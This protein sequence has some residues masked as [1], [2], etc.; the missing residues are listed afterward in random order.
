MIKSVEFPEDF[1]AYISNDIAQD[2]TNQKLKITELLTSF[3][4]LKPLIIFVTKPPVSRLGEI[5]YGAAVYQTYSAI[6]CLQM[7]P[8]NK[9]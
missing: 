4:A 9:P 5:I 7:E 1:R 8:I 3:S 2:T 6:S